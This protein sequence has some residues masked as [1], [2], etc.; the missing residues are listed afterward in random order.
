M[1]KWIW[2]LLI[3]LGGMLALFF[4]PHISQAHTSAALEPAVGPTAVQPNNVSN[5][6]SVELVVTGSGFITGTVVV[7]D[8]YGALTT[9]YVSQNLV[10]AILPANVP[11]GLYS[12]TVINPDA[13]AYTLSNALTITGPVG[14]TATPLATNTPYPT[15]FVRPL[16]VVQSYGASSTAVV[17]GENLDFEITLAN[18]GQ[19]SASNIVATFKNGDFLPRDTGGVRSVEPLASGQ[20][21][22]FFQPLAATKEI[23][24][25]LIA[26]LE[27]DVAYTDANGTAYSETFSLTFPVFRPTAGPPTTATPTPTA[28][29]TITPTPSPTRGPVLRPQL[30]ITGYSTSLTQLQPGLIFDLQIN[31][32][33]QGNTN[34]KRV[35]MILGGGT[36][37]GGTSGGTPEP[38]GLSGSSGEFSKFAPVGSSNVQA[39][40]DLAVDG[41][42]SSTQKLIVNADTAPGA[43]PIKVSFVYNDEAGGS[44]VDDQVITLLVYKRPS[45]E[46]NFYTDPGSFFANQGGSLPLQLVNTGNSAKNFGNFSVSAE[47]ADIQGGSIFVGALDAGGF[48]PLDAFFTPFVSGTMTL[49]LSVEYTDDFNQHQV[50]TTTLPVDVYDAP[51]IEPPIDNGGPIDG[52]PVEPTEPEPEAFSDKL[53]RFL[54]GMIG[55][56]SERPSTDNMGGGGFPTDGGGDFGP[57]DGGGSFGPVDGGGAINIGPIK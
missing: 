53:W 22:R 30:L 4:A 33:N 46:M 39:L 13:N 18:A 5:E 10:R 8:G 7:L 9:S 2:T 36:I 37:S 51:I 57:V 47:N 26:I 35:T 38:G 48:F 19:A 23:A 52:G 44:F 55:L 16:L 40:G 28:T 6:T 25:K 20:S 27:V 17:P 41:S 15:A 34:A 56:S 45:V 49:T 12:L 43:Y 1:P 50:L 24:G 3:L 54:L 29:P 11:P 32:Q 21:S 31:L 14:A 42:L